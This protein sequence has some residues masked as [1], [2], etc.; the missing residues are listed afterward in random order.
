MLQI[1]CS[2]VRVKGIIIKLLA[3]EFVCGQVKIFCYQSDRLQ[4]KKLI[5]SPELLMGGCFIYGDGVWQK[6]KNYRHYLM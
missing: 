6:E 4:E 2:S 1:L 5:S 3:G